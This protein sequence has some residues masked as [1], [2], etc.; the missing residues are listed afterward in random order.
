MYW[1]TLAPNQ[2]VLKAI[3]PTEKKSGR[4]VKLATSRYVWPSL[5]LRSALTTLPHVFMSLFLNK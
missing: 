3:S 4:N 2:G 1:L 5:K